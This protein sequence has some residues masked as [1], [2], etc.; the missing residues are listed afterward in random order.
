MSAISSRTN[1]VDSYLNRKQI[2][3]YLKHALCIDQTL[4]LVCIEVN[5]FTEPSEKHA[6]VTSRSVAMDRFKLAANESRIP[7]SETDGQGI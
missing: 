4:I 1:R 7:S 3:R 5:V 6:H 2:E